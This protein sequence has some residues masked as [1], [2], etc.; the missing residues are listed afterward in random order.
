MFITKD[1]LQLQFIRKL[2][3]VILPMSRTL[4]KHSNDIRASYSECD[5]EDNGYRVTMVYKH[6][7]HKHVSSQPEASDRVW[8]MQ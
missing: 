4:L 1:K 7:G 8:F 6:Q 2:W 3:C 5:I